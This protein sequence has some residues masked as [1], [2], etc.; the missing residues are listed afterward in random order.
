MVNTKAEKSP[1]I[2]A[3]AI[4]SILAIFSA[5]LMTVSLFLYGPIKENKF[6][7]LIWITAQFISGFFFAYLSDKRYRKKALIICQVIGV[8]SGI[9]LALFGMDII[10]MCIIGLFNPLPIA[11]GVLLDNFPK[12]SSLRIIAIT[13]AAQYLTWAFFKN[14][15][16]V[17]Y[18][19][20]VFT[21][22]II[23]LINIFLTA[24]FLTDNYDTEKLEAGKKHLGFV[25]L[26]KFIFK[27]R[28]LALILVA[29]TF[30]ESGFYLLL[31]YFE[32]LPVAKNY[33]SIASW[34]TLIGIGFAIFWRSIPHRSIISILYLLGA[35]VNMIVLYK[36]FFIGALPY[37]SNLVSGMDF[38][39]LIGGFY[40]PMVV[41]MLIRILG[42]EHRAV[43]ASMA[44]FGDTFATFIGSGINLIRISIVGAT[45]ILIFFYIA[46][47]VIQW[48]A[49]KEPSAKN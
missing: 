2:F 12:H 31:D 9:I 44:E 35:G 8:S 25:E 15:G 23:L 46:A 40:L 28:A 47:A 1:K 17:D 16:S 19:V 13:Y 18:R 3:S 7:L 14:L 48:R 49:E 34:S 5:E 45:I 39:T 11:R 26:M 10:T 20:I 29:F 33:L 27:N 41:D 32:Y 42:K 21:S 24:F 30:A 38:Y 6:Y 43:G 4:P 37:I 36:D 22:L